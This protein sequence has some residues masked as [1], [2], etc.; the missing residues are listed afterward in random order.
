V[1]VEGERIALAITEPQKVELTSVALAGGGAVAL[2]RIS[3]AEGREMAALLA[4]NTKGRVELLWSGALDARGDPGERQGD[5]LDLTDRSGDG[6]PDVTVGRF[7]E[8]ANLCGQDRTILYPRQLDTES[9]RLRSVALDRLPPDSG[10]TIEIAAIAQNPGPTGAPLLKRSLRLLGVSS[11]PG[12]E[13]DAPS[14]PVSLTDGDAATFWSEG[15]GAG[16]RGEFATFRWDGAGAAIRA[17]ALVPLPTGVPKNKTVGVA[18]SVWL[19]GDA[20][21]RIKVRL[22]DAPEAGRRYWVVPKQPLN[23]R[24]VSVVFDETS[25]TAPGPAGPS[26][27]ADFEVY[28]DFDFGEGV[29][30]L[31]RDLGSGGPEAGKAAALLATLGPGIAPK[32]LEVWPQ[33]ASAGRRRAVRIVAPHAETSEAARHALVLGLSDAEPEIHAAA[34]AALLEAG[35]KA[36]AAL[37]DEVSRPGEAGDATALA[38]SRRAPGE[39]ISALLHALEQ[40]AGPARAGLR[41]ALTIACRSKDGSVLGAVHAWLNSPSAAVAGRASLALALAWAAGDEAA[42][43]LASAVLA[44]A[45]PT[46]TEFDDLWRLVQAA[47]ILPSDPGVDAWLSNLALHDTRWML[48][49][50]ALTALTDRKSVMTVTT[51]QRALE[52]DYSRVRV[53]AARALAQ[54]PSALQALA[55]HAVRDRWVVVRAAALDAL[56]EFPGAEPLLRRG[57]ADSAHQA[58]AA[59]IRGLTKARVTTAWPLVKNRLEDHDEAPDVLADAVQFARALCIADAARSLASLLRRG[60]EP[61]ASSYESDVGL[62]ALGALIDLGGEPAAAALKTARG[63]AAPTGFRAVAEK[64][65]AQPTVCAEGH[66]AQPTPAGFGAIPGE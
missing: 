51:A 18:R 29:A 62:L 19:V 55:K 42:R 61:D 32:L 65:A 13:A 16:A 30:R 23:W 6:H 48:R 64:L 21:A 66:R 8:Q 2:I 4:R 57:V 60:A 36:R 59:A 47:R 63:R 24:C 9:L 50:S 56:S 38:F 7:S 43:A 26:V 25:A 20:G 3:G 34:L 33:L 53:V 14:A 39:A 27:L 40:E 54:T 37:S 58:R 5:V 15:N 17:F 35:P 1:Q 28:S 49:G 22:P 44:A 52:D 11:E 45:A 31:L 41:S 46:A 10:P 12:K